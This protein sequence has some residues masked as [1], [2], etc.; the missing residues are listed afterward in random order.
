[1][2]STHYYGYTQYPPLPRLF[3]EALFL[4]GLRFDGLLFGGCL[5]CPLLGL[6]GRGLERPQG[7]YGG[8]AGLS[9]RICGWITGTPTAGL[10]G[11]PTAGLTG[12]V[13]VYNLKKDSLGSRNTTYQ[14]PFQHPNFKSQTR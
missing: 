10:T 6:R 9:G 3:I 2:L 13:Q 11:T 8:H 1:M 4:D 7:P 5:H 14:A 12:T